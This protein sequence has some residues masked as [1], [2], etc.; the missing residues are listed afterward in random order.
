MEHP[1]PVLP[2]T[3]HF[4]TLLAHQG[5]AAH[6]FQGPRNACSLRPR[7]PSLAPPQL[8]PPSFT[9]W[10]TES[11][12]GVML[13]HCGWAPAQLWSSRD[14]TWGK[15]VRLHKWHQI[16]TENIYFGSQEKIPFSSS[17]FFSV[18]GLAAVY[19]ELLE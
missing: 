7:Q 13:G 11:Q 1:L 6:L 17:E 5:W 19:L 2:S 15:Q 9:T 12:P 18:T 3:R 10:S 8:K 16:Q 14:R 4:W